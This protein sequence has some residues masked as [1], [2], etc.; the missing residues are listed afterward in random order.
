[1]ADPVVLLV[2]NQALSRESLSV[3]LA[4]RG[5]RV[6]EAPN[7]KAARPLWPNA[8]V[9][10]AA[11]DSQ[12]SDGLTIVGQYSA[13][14]RE[15]RA[16]CLTPTLDARVFVGALYLGGA[17]SLERDWTLAETAAGLRRVLAD[18]PIRSTRDTAAILRKAAR[19]QIH[20]REIRVRLARLTDRESDVLRCMATGLSGPDTAQRLEIS[21]QTERSHVASILKKLRVKS[22]TQAVVLAGAA[23]FVDLAAGYI[24]SLRLD[25][26][27]AETEP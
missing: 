23:G 20:E 27:F 10:L 22:R 12:N 18:E 25:G 7:A 2:D 5:F 24:L 21:H 9:V 11:C 26:P 17:G 8:S 13:S 4:A 16:V 3:A 6:L 15:G 19:A 1:M 14:V